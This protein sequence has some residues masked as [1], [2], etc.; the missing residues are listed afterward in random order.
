[1]ADWKK[2][3]PT[4]HWRAPNTPAVYVIYLDGAPVYVGQ[5]TRLRTRLEQ[6][7]FNWSYAGSLITPWGR[8]HGDTKI[9]CKYRLSR[10]MGDWL[11]WELRL[12]WKLQPRYN[13]R[14]KVKVAA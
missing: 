1:M 3:D 2:I 4:L 8:F 5:T 10:R 14:S 7:K 12:I 9:L 13:I 6:H 11:M